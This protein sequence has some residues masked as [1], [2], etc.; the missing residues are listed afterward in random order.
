MELNYI[1]GFTIPLE[2]K[3][4]NWDT[5]TLLL[6]L[7][8]MHACTKMG[9]QALVEIFCKQNSCVNGKK[10]KCN[11]IHLNFMPKIIQSTSGEFIFPMAHIRSL[12]CCREP[13]L[14]ERPSTT[15]PVSYNIIGLFNYLQSTHE[16]MGKKILPF[17]AS[18]KV[19]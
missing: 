2:Y 8:T 5:T 19:P 17:S 4:Y 3:I 12:D 18:F 11:L 9:L 6:Q 7:F 15:V 14:S 16:Y 10:K 13:H 1:K